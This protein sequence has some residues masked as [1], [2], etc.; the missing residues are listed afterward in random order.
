MEFD[1]SLDPAF[2]GM[3]PHWRQLTH[4]EATDRTT[5]P[6]RV[7]RNTSSNNP[8]AVTSAPAPG[9]WITSGWAA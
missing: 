5:D 2:A 9:P 1:D 4:A 7:K 3:T 8:A 6:Q